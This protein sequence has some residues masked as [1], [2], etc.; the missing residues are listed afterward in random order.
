MVN[1]WSHFSIYPPVSSEA[2][3]G[4]H[5]TTLVPYALRIMPRRKERGLAWL[6]ALRLK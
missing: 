2:Y 3:G 6:T 1:F 4:C 5:T